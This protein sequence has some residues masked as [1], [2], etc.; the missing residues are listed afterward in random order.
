MQ[1]VPT[2]SSMA[3]Y[4]SSVVNAM[5][6]PNQKDPIRLG[7]NNRTRSLHMPTSRLSGAER[8]PKDIS[9]ELPTASAATA[10]SNRTTIADH[11]I[12]CLCSHLRKAGEI[13]CCLGIIV[14]RNVRRHRVWVPKQPLS[15]P[16][17]GR[18]ITLANMLH[19]LKP[20]AKPALEER[21]KL[22]VRLASS[23]LQLHDTE[24]LNERWSKDEIWFIQEDPCRDPVLKYPLVRR[25]F[26]QGD[27]S[28]STDSIAGLIGHSNAS[29]FSLGMVLI[30][31]W[32]WKSLEA[33]DVGD[34]WKHYL[35][36]RGKAPASFSDAVRRCFGDLDH[37]ETQLHLDGFK[38]AVY[39]K[40]VLPLEETLKWF[41]GKDSLPQ[42]FEE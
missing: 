19:D 42:I 25:V 7:R 6:P 14:S 33:K 31:L 30:E 17:L 11:I 4:S 27:E 9:L 2:D 18:A 34:G 24:W 26:Q 29:L 8:K 39:L 5:T 23:V 10:T 22:G 35:E 38:N 28:T 13:H 36:L 20:E 32:Y 41:C 40:I 16:R 37:T 12:S 21:L 3:S 15:I 1:K